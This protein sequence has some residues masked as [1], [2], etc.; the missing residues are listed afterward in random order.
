MIIVQ[1][2]IKIGGAGEVAWLKGK[3]DALEKVCIPNMVDSN[4]S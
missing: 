3:L 4:Q 1:L 2:K